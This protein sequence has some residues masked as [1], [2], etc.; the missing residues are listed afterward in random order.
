MADA[1]LPGGL[2]VIVWVISLVFAAW[3]GASL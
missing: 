3:V 2:M 1:D